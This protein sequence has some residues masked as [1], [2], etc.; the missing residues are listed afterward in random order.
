MNAAKALLICLLFWASAASAAGKSQADTRPL[1][2][3]LNDALFV[4]AA[5]PRITG[6]VGCVPHANPS[7]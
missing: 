7:R 6:A 3:R 2:D 4:R 5:V 1:W